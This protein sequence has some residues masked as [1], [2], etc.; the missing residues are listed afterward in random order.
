MSKPR[1][2]IDI[3]MLSEKL[4]IKV[5]TLYH[6]VHKGEIPHYKIGRLVRFDE[7]VVDGKWLED[8]ERPKSHR[9]PLI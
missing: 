4:S 8:K 7:D 3:K 9:N 5:K 2:L 6:L 1:R